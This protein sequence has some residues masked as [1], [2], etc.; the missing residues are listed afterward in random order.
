[1]A[2]KRT[3]I[4][5]YLHVRDGGGSGVGHLDPEVV[6][7]QVYEEAIKPFVAERYAGQ[8]LPVPIGEFTDMPAAGGPVDND[9]EDRHAG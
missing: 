5:L 6:A 3:R 7:R 9:R 1:M 4:A 2:S 8:V